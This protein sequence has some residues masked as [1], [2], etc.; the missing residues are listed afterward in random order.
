MGIEIEQER[1][2]SDDYKSFGR[3]LQDGLEALELVLNRPGFGTGERTIGAE[4]E[5]FLVDDDGR[6]APVGDA[7]QRDTRNELVTPELGAF[8]IEL[9]TPPVELAGTPF[10]QLH[11]DMSRVIDA[12]GA[13]AQAHGARAVAVGILPTFVP[14]DFH[15]AVITNRPRYR[16]LAA[17]VKRLRQAPFR[18]AIDGEDPLELV[19]DNIA[20][21]GANVAFQ[22]HVRTAPDEFARLYN[23]ALLL[24]APV[25]AASANS[26]TFLGHRLWHETRVALF[27]QSSD[28]RTPDP[29]AEWRLPP[30]VGF[31]NGWVREG[32]LEL[33]M[34]SVALH[35]PLLPVCGGENP[36][37]CAREGGV[38]RLDELRLHH[39]TVWQWNRPVYDP[40]DGGHLR[41]E[42]R[43]LPSGP[44]LCDMLGNAA[45]LIGSMLALA[46]EVP[47]LL[48][49][50]PFAL[51]ER[52]FYRAAQH[53]LDAELIWPMHPGAPPQVITARD[54]LLDLLPRAEAGLL[55][56]GVRAREVDGCLS[57]F[58]ARVESGVTGAV[59][60]RRTFEAL[61]GEGLPRPQALQAMLERYMAEVAS[62]EPVH[63]WSLTG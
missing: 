55:C 63:A 10:S 42:L 51:A 38:P 53:G 14:S 17:G 1:F 25:L 6:P 58:A 12:I 16:A 8:N 13:A 36:L 18:I 5:L 34:E 54:L 2:G 44:T 45:F 29:H 23:A 40:A 31:G 3:K 26:P 46:D 28:D 49:S 27:K 35:E 48:P 30:R 61:R 60:Q 59:W 50:L 47:A 41:I 62:G 32:A 21:E 39:G 52:N 15:K 57:A 11:G 24:T 22:V 20:V 33:F 43:A 7:V 37:A 19:S 9:G 4:L 56:A